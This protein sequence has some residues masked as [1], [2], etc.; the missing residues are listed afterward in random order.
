MSTSPITSPVS[1]RRELH[2]AIRKWAEFLERIMAELG[3]YHWIGDLNDHLLEIVRR[4]VAR[5]QFEAIQA[6]QSMCEKGHGHFGVTMLRPAYEELIWMEYL[7]RHPARANELVGL[8]A[9]DEISNNL[10]AQNDYI[11]AAGMLAHGFSQRFVKVTL[12]KL[13]PFEA[14]LRQIGKELG[15]REGAL[16]P[17]MA[18]VARKVGR[19]K[20]YKFLYQGTSRYVHFSAQEVLRRVWGRNGQVAITSATFSA[21]WQDFAVYWSFYI[22]INLLSGYGDLL[23]QSEFREGIG[24]ELKSTLSAISPVPIITAGELESW[25]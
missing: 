16:L 4:G 25:A 15:W 22:I 23:P 24:E 19:E 2:V 3:S 1:G 14:R 7:A 8:I 17:S 13:K 20:E 12:A 18:F 21:Y 5:R 11:G 6:I 10:A 9:R